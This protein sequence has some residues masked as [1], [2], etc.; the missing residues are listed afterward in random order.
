MVQASMSTIASFIGQFDRM[1]YIVMI[2]VVF[3][4]L[5]EV[6]IVLSAFVAT[7]SEADRG[8]RPGPRP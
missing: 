5:W 2:A 4:L 6:I 8:R 1:N 7:M 3:V